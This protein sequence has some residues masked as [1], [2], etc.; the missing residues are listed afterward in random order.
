MNMELKTDKQAKGTRILFGDTA[1]KRRLMIDT[2][3][4]IADQE[5]LHGS[6]V[7]RS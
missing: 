1:K 3:V 7:A 2:L 6:S 5:G 4:R